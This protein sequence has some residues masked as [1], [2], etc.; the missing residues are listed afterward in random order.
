MHAATNQARLLLVVQPLL[1]VVVRL[2]SRSLQLYTFHL[3][4]QLT[5]AMRML[6]LQTPTLATAP[7]RRLCGCGQRQ[8]AGKA[9]G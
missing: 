4:C 7:A 3:P 9:A 2:A 5:V 1:V 6:L 8:Q